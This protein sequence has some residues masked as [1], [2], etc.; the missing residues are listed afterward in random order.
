M[1]WE[2]KHYIVVLYRLQL[3]LEMVHMLG[4]VGHALNWLHT[5]CC[6]WSPQCLHWVLYLCGGSL[7]FMFWVL[8]FCAWAAY[9][10]LPGFCNSNKS[11]FTIKWLPVIYMSLCVTFSSPRLLLAPLSCPTTNCSTSIVKCLSLG[12]NVLSEVSNNY[13]FNT[14]FNCTYYKRS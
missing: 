10:E 7:Y 9:H 3:D 11:H 4:L 5:A 1:T 8:T 13:K 2:W 14:Y 12:K 6:V